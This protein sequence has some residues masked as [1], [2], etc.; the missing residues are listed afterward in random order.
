MA[1]A[2]LCNGPA[3]DIELSSGWRWTFDPTHATQKVTGSVASQEVTFQ[4]R[5]SLLTGASVGD[6][7]STLGMRTAPITLPLGVTT[8]PVA[9]TAQ[10]G[11]SK[12]YQLEFDRGATVIEQAIYGKASNTGAG[13]TFGFSLALS[14]DTLAIGA[15]GEASAATNVNSNQADNSAFYAGAVYV[16]VRSGITW[17]QQAYLKASNTGAYDAF[18]SSLALAGNTLVVGAPGEASAATGINGNQGNN[19]A[20]NAGAVYVFVRSGTSWMQQAYLKASNTG[21]GDRFG[22]SLALSEGT[23]VVGAPG[24]ASA[25]TGVNG[26]QADNNADSAGAVY[27]FIRSGVIW[28]Q[29]AYLKASNTGPDD[30]FGSSLALSG[31]TLAVGAPHEASASTG[32]NGDQVNNSADNAGAVYVFARSAAIW[33]QQVYLKASN[34]G[35]NDRFGFSLAL[36]IDTLIVGAPYEASAAT[37]LNGN[38]ADNSAF[39]AGAVYAFVRF[40]STWAQQAYLKASNTEIFDNFGDSLAL[41]R[42]TLAVGAFGEDSSSTG[43]DGNQL[44]NGATGAGATYVFVRSGTAW[45][46]KAYLKASNTDAED[47]FGS[48]LALSG[49]TLVIGATNEA[50]AAQGVNGNQ[51][52]NSAGGAGAVYIFH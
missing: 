14:G 44:D 7:A 24:E 3:V 41:S 42:D 5:G 2:V 37:G 6:V 49:D 46:Q 52:D 19:T 38:Q 33:A 32:V 26:N 29:E 30:L 17:V 16:F 10:E 45:A 27:V 36:S 1:V 9:L 13:D 40:G 43:V 8:V 21:S 47:L 34:T 48:S 18:G 39:N 15:R 23:L 20:S 12:T 28:I 31:D 51:A 11:L 25:S 35:T 50:S 22:S 4:I